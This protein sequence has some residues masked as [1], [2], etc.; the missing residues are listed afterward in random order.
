[1]KKIFTFM[2][3]FS[4]TMAWSGVTTYT[5][6]SKTWTSRVDAT[7]CD[8]KTDGWLSDKDAYDYYAGSTYAD[9]SLNSRGVSVKTSTP[10]AGATSVVAF[11]DVRR[12]TFNLCQN[13]SKGRGVICVQI[14]EGPVDSLVINRP[15]GSGTGTRNRDS[16][17]YI[18]PGRSGHIRFWVHCTE[19]AININTLTIHSASGGSSPFTTAT[20]RLVTSED[21]LQDSDRI[22]VGVMRA[23]TP[24][25]MGYYDESVSQNNIHAIGGRYSAD[26]TVVADDV[27][28]IYT[29]CRTEKGW[30]IID[31]VRYDEAYL[32]A[33]GGATKNRLALWY[34]PS[35]PVYGDYGYWDIRVAADG[36]ATI[37]SRGN[38]AG[39]YLQYNAS[40]S[41]SLFGCYASMS[42]TPVCLYRRVEALGDKPAIVAPLVRFDDVAMSGT[43][44]SGSRTITVNANRLTED[45]SIR[46]TD[47]T[48]FQSDGAVLDR[49]GGELTIRY[50][51][52]HAGKYQDTLV[53]TS[54]T[55]EVRVPVMLN[56]I[57]TLT[58]AEALAEP[59]YT[60]LYLNDVVVTK[61]YDRYVFVRD[62]TGSM[63]L[64]DRGDGTGKRYAAGVEQGDV[65]TGVFG[66]AQ[67]YYGVPELSLIAPFTTRGT[68]VVEPEVLTTVDSAD[69]CRFVRLEGVMVQDGRCKIN[70]RE[71]TVTDDFNVTAAE[72][73]VSTLDA[74]VMI[75]YDELQL[76]LVSQTF[77]T[78]IKMVQTDKESDQTWDVLGR[79]VS[80]ETRGCVVRKGTKM[81]R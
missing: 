37:M 23:N 44:V 32:V 62:E 72:Y 29:L 52:S 58:V 51:V 67:N 40:N 26:R 3:L 78:G 47:G 31:D 77:P 35:S 65:L 8:G 66:K 34:T 49:E 50:T 27:R 61:K 5:F 69:V 42:Q 25:I 79:S 9:G 21:Q 38:S 64:F 43:T 70:G 55:I 6:T 76:W 12:I 11:T 63:C 13:S 4:V 10:D 24:Y 80:A 20:Y 17:L 33:N 57:P 7:I 59:D 18:A 1:M 36:A 16:V 75:S 30:T 81:L 71:L 46:L 48:V 45:I 22:I 73:I 41:P 19:N 60:S 2:L 74:I 39:K 14:G 54:D 28:A 53:L 68:A 56:V 15:V